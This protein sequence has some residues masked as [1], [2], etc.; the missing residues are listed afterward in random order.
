MVDEVM[1]HRC[2]Y[3]GCV[4]PSQNDGL[5]AQHYILTLAGL[6]LVEVPIEFSTLSGGQRNSSIKPP[7]SRI[8]R[9]NGYIHLI[10][11]P[12][13]PLALRWGR[14]FICEHT[15][16]MQEKFGRK[17][18]S[19]ETVHHKNTIRSCNE[20]D[21]LELWTGGRGSQPPGGRVDDVQSW[22]ISFLSQYGY[23][24]TK[25]TSLGD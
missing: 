5:C 23:V 22:A 15:L 19:T 4:N 11:V 13:H 18:L 25:S 17:L 2:K 16:Y 14:C 8:L 7:F 10:F 3:P 21:N 24:V 1:T 6:P 20:L 12:T 9:K